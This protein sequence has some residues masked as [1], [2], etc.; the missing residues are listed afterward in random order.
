LEAYPT[1]AYL[2]SRPAKL[3][4]LIESKE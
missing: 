4:L 1:A 3:H 2:L